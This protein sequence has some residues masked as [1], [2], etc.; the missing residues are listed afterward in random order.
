LPDC[1]ASLIISCGSINPTPSPRIA[2][3]LP[4]AGLEALSHMNY[5]Y[6]ER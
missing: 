1:A 2:T 5:N 4:S 3:P 6:K